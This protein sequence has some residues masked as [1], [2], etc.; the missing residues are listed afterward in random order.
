MTAPVLSRA[1]TSTTD[2]ATAHGLTNRHT[3][4]LLEKLRQRGLVE[5]AVRGDAA[6]VWRLAD[7]ASTPGPRRT[8]TSTTTPRGNTGTP[9]GDRP[10]STQGG[11]TGTRAET[12]AH[13]RGQ[14]AE[15][16][17]PESTQQRGNTGAAPH[18]GQPPYTRSKPRSPVDARSSGA[19]GHPARGPE[20]PS[21]LTSCA[22]TGSRSRRSR[23][24][25]RP[26]WRPRSRGSC[27]R[28]TRGKQPA[29]SP[30]HCR[31]GGGAV[32]RVAPV[33]V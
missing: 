13:E 23:R 7:T 24:R 12:T 15:R 26:R 1:W 22:W 9:I 28:A 5:R 30:A 19:R 25:R 32:R 16:H 31:G 27:S 11:T 2:L 10:V 3:R 8:A 17:T 18:H 4:N 14:T 20:A 6:E 21:C 29:P 33:G